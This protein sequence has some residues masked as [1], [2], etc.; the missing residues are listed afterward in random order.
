MGSAKAIAK[1]LGAGE[2]K[3]LSV[4]DVAD[5]E[6]A[7]PES[8]L[9]IYGIETQAGPRIPAGEIEVKVRVIVKCSY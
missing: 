7:S 4:T 5:H 3:V 2:V 8:L 6:K 1:G 9:N